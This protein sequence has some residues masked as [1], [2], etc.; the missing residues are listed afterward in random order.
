MPSAGKRKHD[1][2]QSPASL[3]IVRGE[4]SAGIRQI[5]QQLREAERAAG[6]LEAP[7]P[8]RRTY[9]ET[10]LLIAE[11]VYSMAGDSLELAL[12]FVKSRRRNR[13]P[14]AE[15]TTDLFRARLE[16]RTAAE[17]TEMWSAQK[18]WQRRRAEARDFLISRGLCSWTQD[19]NIT[20]AIA[21]STRAALQEID[22][23][24]AEQ[25]AVAWG[26]ET[27]EGRAK[28]SRRNRQWI[29]RWIARFQLS[30]GRFQPGP[31]VQPQEAR[32]K[33]CLETALRRK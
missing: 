33:V 26:T 15:M 28:L 27:T 11:L 13:H 4:L 6:A 23:M 29:R 14:S 1:A 3:K 19:M 18:T 32:Q 30:R 24:R 21:P 16:E 12:D 25:P 8:R 9:Y 2:S 17:W 22:R 10:T 31:A 20:K 7:E 5:R